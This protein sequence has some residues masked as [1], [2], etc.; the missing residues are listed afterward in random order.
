MDP[1]SQAVVGA[2]L[3][4]SIA[5]KY[6]S[7]KIAFVIGALSGMAADL[8]VLIQSP[9]DPLLFLEY[10]RQFTHSLIFIPIGGLICALIFYPFLKQKMNFTSLYLFSALGYGTHGLLESK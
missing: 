10:H 6:H 5:K 9:A 3:T 1:I 4:Q 2:T 7:Q 8:D